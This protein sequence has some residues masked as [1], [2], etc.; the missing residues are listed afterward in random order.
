MKQLH[1]ITSDSKE[2][3]HS[4][5]LVRPC[6][7]VSNAPDVHVKPQ[8]Q[9]L[10]QTSVSVPDILGQCSSSPTDRTQISVRLS[11]PPDLDHNPAVIGAR[12]MDISK[13]YGD[14]TLEF[15]APEYKQSDGNLHFHCQSDVRSFLSL[16]TV[17][18]C[19]SKSFYDSTV[20]LCDIFQ[21]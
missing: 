10:L 5:K 3:F 6:Y 15:Y 1:L 19:T 13:C 8:R 4:R 12:E 9:C 7:H 14:I 17:E 21:L 18:I 2:P 11:P 16:S 20:F